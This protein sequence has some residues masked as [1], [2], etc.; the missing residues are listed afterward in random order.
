MVKERKQQSQDE[1]FELEFSSIEENTDGKHEKVADVSD[2]FMVCF[3]YNSCTIPV[4][5]CLNIKKMSIPR[6]SQ[7]LGSTKASHG[8]F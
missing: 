6:Y 8:E 4:K 2:D 3:L 7:Q 1:D 5:V